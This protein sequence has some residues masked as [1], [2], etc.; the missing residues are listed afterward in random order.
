MKWTCFPAFPAS[1]LV[2]VFSPFSFPD[3]VCHRLPTMGIVLLLLLLSALN[4]VVSREAA[5]GGGAAPSPAPPP[6]LGWGSV[7][8][9]AAV[10]A[11]EA[12]F[13]HASPD[14]SAAVPHAIAHAA[15]Q[16]CGCRCHHQP[17][18]HRP[19]TMSASMR[20]SSRWIRRGIKKSTLICR[21]SSSRRNSNVSLVNY[22]EPRTRYQL[23]HVL[24]FPA[25]LLLFQ[26]W[27]TLTTDLRALPAA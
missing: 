4:T 17:P 24:A 6:A 19:A 8:A 23:P 5:C 13:L 20:D 9:A 18:H 21:H 25:S 27:F 10:P 26:L 2:L 12:A 22:E 7:P 15:W 3:T 11:D 14:P 1:P 16:C